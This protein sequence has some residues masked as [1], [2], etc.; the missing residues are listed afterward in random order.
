MF[1][2]FGLTWEQLCLCAACL[3][4]RGKGEMNCES[5][6]K[7]RGISVDC[8]GNALLL[9]LYYFPWICKRTLAGFWPI[10]TECRRHTCNEVF[11]LDLI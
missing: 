2:E 7:T 9:S 6:C 4:G 1:S 5:V 11:T 8:G 10:L 3:S